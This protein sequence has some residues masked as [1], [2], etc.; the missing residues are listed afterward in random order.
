MNHE[1][2]TLKIRKPVLLINILSFVLILE[3][4][5]TIISVLCAPAFLCLSLGSSVKTQ[6]WIN[7]AK[8]KRNKVIL[9]LTKLS[10]LQSNRINKG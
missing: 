8:Q 6:S 7:N 10:A 5:T 3:E 1:N 9:P 2:N 4:R